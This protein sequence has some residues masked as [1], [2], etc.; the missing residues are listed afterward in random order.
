MKYKHI[1]IGGTFDLLHEG[2]K[3]FI[4]YAFS[5]GERMTIGVTSDELVKKLKGGSLQGFDH[6]FKTV[7]EF[8]KISKFSSRGSVMRLDDF[9]G[10]TLNDKTIDCLLI[11]RVSLKGA[12]IINKARVNL[13][14][15][16]LQVET[17][18]LIR[19]SDKQAISSKRIK[20]GVINQQGLNY[21]EYLIKKGDLYLPQNLRWVLRKPFGKVYEELGKIKSLNDKKRLVATVGDY[22]TQMF[23]KNGISPDL[24]VIDFK[25][26]R[27][28]TFESVIDLGFSGQEKIINAV[29]PP[30]IISQGLVEA[31]HESLTTVGKNKTIVLVDGEED[32]SVLVLSL[33]TPLGSIIYYGIRNIGLVEVAVDLKLKDELLGLIDL[34][35]KT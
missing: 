12:K 19:G 27:A 31:I 15:K 4:R 33:M 7:C 10:P 8:I 16:D 24:S 1:A 13:G 23:L 34:F 5:L 18:P 17:F 26:Q 3:Q 22:T 14:L 30:G 20:N 6:R 28:D 9:F 32:L 21:Y 11:T 29:S 35:E 25:I 2:H